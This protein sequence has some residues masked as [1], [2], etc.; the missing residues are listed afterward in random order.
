VHPDVTIFWTLCSKDVPDQTAYVA[1]NFDEVTCPVCA[2]ERWTPRDPNG[3][4]A[5]WVPDYKPGND[6]G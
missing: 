2:K 5:A 4:E 6:N 3:P 1:D